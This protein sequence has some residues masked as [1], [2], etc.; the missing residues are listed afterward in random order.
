[1]KKRSSKFA[2]DVMKA[3]QK[4]GRGKKTG[5][6]ALE[7]IRT[8]DEA[9][10]SGAKRKPPRRYVKNRSDG[11]A[12]VYVVDGD[13]RKSLNVAIRPG[14][15]EKQVH[16]V[17]QVALDKYVERRNDEYLE[18]ES[19]E[20]LTLWDIHKRWV[21]LLR[22]SS[23]IQ[24][25]DQRDLYGRHLF[26]HRPDMRYG[27]LKEVFGLDYVAYRVAGI[28]RGKKKDAATA[29]AIEHLRDFATALELFLRSVPVDKIRRFIMPEFDRKKFPF[30]LTWDWFM[31][32][33]L[34]ARGWDW[35]KE[36]DCWKK[37]WDP[38]SGRW[39]LCYDRNRRDDAL[40]R[41]IMFYAFSGT[42]DSTIPLLTWGVGLEGGTVNAEG[43]IIVRRPPGHER[44]N[45]RAE[46]ADMFGPLRTLVKPW[47]FADA[48]LLTKDV[49]H[50][51]VG[52][53]INDVRTR[54]DHAADLA[55][56]SWVTPHF[57]KHFG[58]TIY[59]YAGVDRYDLADA[60]CTQASTLW[61]DYIHLQVKWRDKARRNVDGKTVTLWGLRHVM[62][63]SN[64]EWLRA[65]RRLKEDWERRQR[66][67]AERRARAIEGEGVE[68]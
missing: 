32:I 36:N 35:D 45:K 51:D 38:D 42:R 13:Q 29:Y 62:P 15:T 54:F 43:G 1:M 57:C 56:L 58:A 10:P 49:I 11:A 19:P 65:A 9:N 18:E 16:A 14:M 31:R 24:T 39:V 22:E 50:D 25:S 63:P 26:Q 40:V 2:Q 60:F 68:A 12:M 27:D 30:Y 46:P 33:V 6:K 5:P 20:D 44:T 67:K 17:S 48:L 7:V 52:E 23:R 53:P 47:A 41:Y 34:I 37:R 66:E 64:E 61:R 55:G 4:Q 8:V 21:E 59:T 3:L 28:P